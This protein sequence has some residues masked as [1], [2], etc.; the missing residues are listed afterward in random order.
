MAKAAGLINIDLVSK[1]GYVENM[2]EWNDPL[3]RGV[4]D[5]LPSG[6]KMSDYVTSLYVTARKCGRA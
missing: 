1:A 4:R 3:Y 6:A 5:Q 2:T